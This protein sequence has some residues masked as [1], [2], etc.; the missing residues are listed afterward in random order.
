MN[1]IMHGRPVRKI[2]FPPYGIDEGGVVE[3]NA[4]QGLYLSATH[5]G[6]HD[7]FWVVAYDKQNQDREIARYN[8]KYLEQ[9]DWLND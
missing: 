7:E 4:I 6:D 2:Y 3:S 8:V 9:I 5:H 1:T